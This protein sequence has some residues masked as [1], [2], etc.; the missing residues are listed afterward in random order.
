[1]AGRPVAAEVFT[2]GSSF[3]DFSGSLPACAS[4]SHS[5]GGSIWPSALA[6]PGL[7]PQCQCNPGS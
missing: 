1:M 3:D 5:G 7:V 6:R 2:G 4:T